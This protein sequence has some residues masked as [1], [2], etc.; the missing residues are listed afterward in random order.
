MHHMSSLD[1]NE[2]AIV[3]LD[4]GRVEQPLVESGAPLA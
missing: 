4:G 2:P 1:A 3:I